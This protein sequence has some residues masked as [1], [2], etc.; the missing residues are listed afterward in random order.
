MGVFGAFLALSVIENIYS[1]L[2][3]QTDLI[4][5]RPNCPDKIEAVLSLQYSH[6]LF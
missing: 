3:Y 2:S 4:N 5:F 6:I 1:F